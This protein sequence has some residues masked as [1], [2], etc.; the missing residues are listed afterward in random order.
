MWPD[1]VANKPHA[2]NKLI[3]SPNYNLYIHCCCWRFGNRCCLCRNDCSPG[4]AVA[5]SK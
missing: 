4:V 5:D 2:A 1:T 3:N